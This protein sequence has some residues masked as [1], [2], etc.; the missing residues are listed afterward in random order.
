MTIEELAQTLTSL[1]FAEIEKVSANALSNPDADF[2][3]HR[4]GTLCEITLWGMHPSDA[5]CLGYPVT[6]LPSRDEWLADVRQ[7]RLRMRHDDDPRDKKGN[8]ID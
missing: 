6:D 4:G 7:E 2:T 8:P 3:L 1:G 5:V